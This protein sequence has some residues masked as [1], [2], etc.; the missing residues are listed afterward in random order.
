MRRLFVSFYA[1][2]LVFTYVSCKAQKTCGSLI[3]WGELEADFFVQRLGIQDTLK[4]QGNTIVFIMNTCKGSGSFKVY[5]NLG[6]LII[7]GQYIDSPITFK[8]RVLS[9]DIETGLVTSSIDKYYEG[10]PDGVWKYYKDN[11]LKTRGVWQKGDLI[12]LESY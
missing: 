1:V 10:L 9:E 11:K 8:E 5:N 7:A 2:L 4:T 6:E 3:K 12:E